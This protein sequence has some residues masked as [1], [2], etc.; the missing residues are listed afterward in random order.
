MDRAAVAMTDMLDAIRE[1]QAAGASDQQLAEVFDLQ[2]KAMWRLDYISSENSMGFH[3]DQEAARILA[4]SIDFSRQAQAMA[5]R[6][7]APEAPSTAD[8]PVE[9]VQGVTP[10]G[11]APVDPP[12]VPSRQ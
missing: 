2:R 11:G 12:D 10:E 8:L 7:R 9:P 6:M 3:A 4:E 1:A 5:V